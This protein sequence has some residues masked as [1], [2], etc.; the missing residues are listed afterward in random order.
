VSLAPR[1]LE[2]VNSGL[3][4]GREAELEALLASMLEEG[5]R[6]WPGVDLPA[7]AFV[8]HLAAR[9][10]ADGGDLLAHLRGL[11][12]ADLYLAC[13]CALRLPAAL[14]AF[15]AAYVSRLSGYLARQDAFASVSDEIKQ[16]LR[17]RLLVAE[18]GMLPRIGS[19]TGRGSLA[20]W[21]Q[22]TA[23]RLAVD[24]RR[25]QAAETAALDRLRLVAVDHRSDP[26]LDYLRTRYAPELARALDVVLGGLP[27]HDATVLRLYHFEGMTAEAI[28]AL[29]RV[30][31]RTVV[32]WLARLRQ[33]ILD[34]T[35]AELRARLRL[36]TSQ[37]DSLIGTLQTELGAALARHA[38][39]AAP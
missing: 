3:A 35:H 17:A 6:A 1:L 22:T 19:Y 28:A 16:R 33:S 24:M 15:D 30:T 18:G 26:E 12:A 39:R 29:Y 5:R 36:S 31:R 10:P 32:R 38:A 25:A 21:L 4:P 27:A 11:R 23:A 14:E 13:A 8:D 7:D 37:V 34:A 20:G 2:Q 9:A